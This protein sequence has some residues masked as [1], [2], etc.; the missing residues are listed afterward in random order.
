MASLHDHER[1]R[2]PDPTGRGDLPSEIHRRSVTR[3]KIDRRGSAES[4]VGLP[5]TMSVPVRALDSPGTVAAEVGGPQP[6]DIAGALV[7]NRVGVGRH[8]QQAAQL[9]DR[10]E[11]LARHP[12]RQPVQQHRRVLSST[13]EH[14][15]LSI[16]LITRL[17]RKRRERRPTSTRHAT[18][19]PEARPYREVRL[20]FRRRI[21]SYKAAD[22]CVQIIAPTFTPRGDSHRRSSERRRARPA[23]LWQES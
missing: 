4:A 6:G 5:M 14:R 9:I 8:R 11:S 15:S 13:S 19:N 3:S 12:Y 20:R 1:T 23:S 10:F 18:E 16:R 22:K 21:R 17:S 7:G 2:P